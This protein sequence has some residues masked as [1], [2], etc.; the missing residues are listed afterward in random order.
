MA[1]ARRTHDVGSMHAPQHGDYVDSSD[2]LLV[3]PSISLID[4]RPPFGS[5]ISL[6][7]PSI[8]GR[9]TGT[10][11]PVASIPG[12]GV[13]FQ[14]SWER[15]QSASQPFSMPP[16]HRDFYGRQTQQGL[17]ASMTPPVN[18]FSQT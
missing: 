12:L 1:D 2:A 8:L 15:G 14:G 13:G 3:P 9:P 7:E 4:S 16:T 6:A 17:H 5:H 11:L 18:T 10:F